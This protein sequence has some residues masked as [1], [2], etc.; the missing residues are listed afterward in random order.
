[1][2]FVLWHFA[3]LPLTMARGFLTSLEFNVPSLRRY[4][5]FHALCSN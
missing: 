2:H 4:F 1:M 3:I 5:P